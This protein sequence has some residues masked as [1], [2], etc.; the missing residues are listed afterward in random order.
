MRFEGVCVCVG[1]CVFVCACA[2]VHERDRQREIRKKES[3]KQHECPHSDVLRI[4]ESIRWTRRR[5]CASALDSYKQL[6]HSCSLIT[7][8]WD[9][10]SSES[11]VRKHVIQSMHRS[12]RV[13]R[14]SA[15][16]CFI[17]V[18]A[19]TRGASIKTRRLTRCHTSFL[20]LPLFAAGD[21]SI[22]DMSPGR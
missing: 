19:T 4:S 8:H 6:H 1:V 20:L 22:E 13:F 9:I 21:R 17:S 15:T 18:T 7:V 3:K 14:G 12:S 10:L 2:S 5:C 11:R 16:S